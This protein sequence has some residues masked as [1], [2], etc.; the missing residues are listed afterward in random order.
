MSVWTTI[1]K[2]VAFC[3][4]ERDPSSVFVKLESSQAGNIP[5]DEDID[6]AKKLTEQSSRVITEAVDSVFSEH[7]NH[8]YKK[9]RRDKN[10]LIKT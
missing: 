7:D 6:K 8:P 9:I 5:H 1:E 3:G 10:E 2:L 4:V